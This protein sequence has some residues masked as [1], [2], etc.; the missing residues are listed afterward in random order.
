MVEH[1]FSAVRHAFATHPWAIASVSVGSMLLSFLLLVVAVIAFPADYFSR[2]KPPPPRH[3]V[4]AVLLIVAKNVTGL[5]LVG[6]GIILSVPGV[7]GQGVLTIFIGLLMLD[8][9]RKRQLERR[10][11]KNQALRRFLNDIRRRFGRPPLALP[12]ELS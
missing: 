12:T 8:L 4:V 1:F 5:L 11:L 6:L 9:P 3:P 2:A 10:L 7:P